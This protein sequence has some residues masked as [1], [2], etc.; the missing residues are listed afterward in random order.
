MTYR[1]NLGCTARRWGYWKCGSNLRK[2]AA[3]KF[4]VEAWLRVLEHA[5]LV[6]FW[7]QGLWSGSQATY[8]HVCL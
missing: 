2:M 6:G 3:R 7:E 1:M 8:G 4:G 5:K